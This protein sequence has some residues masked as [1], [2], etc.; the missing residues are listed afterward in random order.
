[1]YQFFNKWKGNVIIDNSITVTEA[2]Y[3]N[4]RIT[5]TG[6][7]AYWFPVGIGQWEAPAGDE[8]RKI[9]KSE[10]IFPCLFSF[11]AAED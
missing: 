11:G 4:K 5:S 3:K 10:H 8:C 7:L 6:S 1:M 9:I 2:R